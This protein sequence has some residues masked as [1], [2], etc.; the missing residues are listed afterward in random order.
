L[1]TSEHHD[2]IEDLGVALEID[3]AIFVN[4][5]VPHQHVS[6]RDTYALED[7]VPVILSRKPKLRSNVS[8]LNSW[9]SSV[10]LDFS[11]WDEESLNTHFLSIHYEL[12]IH[13]TVRPSHS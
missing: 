12:S 1:K 10:S 2:G 4:V 6:A 13:H 3:L 7:A 9:E 5:D 8:H 11:N